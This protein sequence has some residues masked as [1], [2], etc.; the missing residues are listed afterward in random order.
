MLEL[1]C[2]GPGY[3]EMQHALTAFAPPKG[4]FLR[5][6]DTGHFSTDNSRPINDQVGMCEAAF[7]KRLRR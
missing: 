2:G 1:E 3:P 4:Q 6:A 5:L 7:A